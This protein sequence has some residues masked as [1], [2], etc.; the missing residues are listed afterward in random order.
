MLKWKTGR[1]TE[2]KTRAQPH[3]GTRRFRVGFFPRLAVFCFFL[4]T[5]VECPWGRRA[6]VF[7]M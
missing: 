6:H 5:K 4:S 7:L 1:V 2:K 3:Q